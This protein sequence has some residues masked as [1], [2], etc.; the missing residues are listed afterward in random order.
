MT[1][2]FGPRYPDT[3]CLRH[4][5]IVGWRDGIDLDAKDPRDC[6]FDFSK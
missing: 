3:G 6:T 5:C 1:T 2:S 4:P